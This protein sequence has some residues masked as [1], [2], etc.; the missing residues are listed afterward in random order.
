MK[1]YGNSDGLPQTQ[2]QALSQDRRGILCIGTVGGFATY[3]GN[4]FERYTHRSGL[5][6]LEITAL[7][8]Q[9]TDKIFIGTDHGLVVYSHFSLEPTMVSLPVTAVRSYGDNAFFTT[10]KG[11]YY[12]REGQL[13]P[14]LEEENLKFDIFPNG[15]LAILHGKE[16]FLGPYNKL[17]PKSLSFDGQALDIKIHNRDVL[18]MSS[19]GIHRLSGGKISTLLHVQ[20]PSAFTVSSDG[21]LWVAAL[22]TLY[23][24]S[25]GQWVT[26][27]T[28]P[29]PTFE[30]INCIMVDREKNVWLGK[31]DGL[32][33]I[34]FK[35]M[36]VYG[37]EDGF[38]NV[39]IR[40]IT[41]ASGGGVFLGGIDFLARFDGSTGTYAPLDNPVE[42]GGMI[43]SI[44]VLPSGVR[45]LGTQSHGLYVQ[46]RNRTVHLKSIEDRETGSIYQM[47]E[48]GTTVWIACDEGLLTCTGDQCTWQN[49][50]PLI[51]PPIYSIA[52]D[53]DNGIYLGT[54]QGVRYLKD[55]KVSTPK[56]LERLDREEINC[57]KFDSHGNLWIGTHGAGLL[58]YDGT[59]L[60]IFDE[61]TA[62]PNDFLWD[63]IEDPDGS[64]WA[65]SNRGIHNLQQNRWLTF[66]SRD[67]LPG[68]EIFIHTA[69]RDQKGNLYF[70]LPRGLL[71]VLSDKRSE[72]VPPLPEVLVRLVTSTTQSL[73]Y[74]EKPVI[75]PPQDRSLTVDFA[76]TSL[77]NESAILYSHRLKNWS[78]EWTTPS[79]HTHV[80]YTGLKPGN[81]IFEVKALDYANRWTSSKELPIILEPAWHETVLFK[82]LV[83]FASLF[84]IGFLIFMRFRLLRIKQDELQ[85]LVDERTRELKAT[86]E[87]VE[88]LSVTDSLT[89]LHNRRFFMENFKQLLA[90]GARLGKSI[91]FAMIDMDNFKE[92]NDKS[93]HLLGDKILRRFGSL[94]TDHFRTSDL[95]ARYGGDEFIVGLIT[96][97]VDSV[98]DRFSRFANSVAATNLGPE[99]MTIY[100]TV[101]IGISVLHPGTSETITFDHMA[102]AADRALYSSKAEGKNRL[103]VDVIS[104]G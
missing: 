37:V 98:V 10:R 22:S 75:L 2:I 17:S 48:I 51:S 3:D 35:H 23:Y 53:R 93:G 9:G 31:D 47:A 101:S 28:I 12:L 88:N 90:L 25:R 52:T 38:P 36:V 58:R 20:N 39:Y 65:C 100:L 87:E 57:L 41:A 42:P 73:N 94:L 91:C 67:G 4:H 55:G 64:I 54:R 21:E 97:D 85:A 80:Q 13:L 72:E 74:P 16:I 71:V 84:V 76:A 56:G 29:T 49:Y 19:S 8:Q 7:S 34:P 59:S 40:S 86:M 99:G 104:P 50:E 61:S 89:G 78:D 24:F 30:L 6:A 27:S 79:P 5:P 68:D 43:R 32:S 45:Y 82:G 60:D 95:V 92:I 102:G 14:V 63:I 44:L 11:L 18:I 103:A 70:A 26:V 33:K 1:I 69:E 77:K 96:N 46:F 81:Y 62:F 83:L 15:D 66:N